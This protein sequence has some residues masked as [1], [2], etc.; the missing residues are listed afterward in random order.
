[1]GGIGKC[2]HE[3]TCDEIICWLRKEYSTRT[4][5][6]VYPNRIEVN[7]PKVRFFGCLGCGSWNADNITSH[8]FG[9]YTPIWFLNS[10]FINLTN[11]LRIDIQI[12]EH[13]VSGQS[14][15]VLETIY[16]VYGM[17][18]EV[19]WQDKDV[20]VMVHYGQGSSIVEVRNEGI[21]NALL[22]SIYL[23]NILVYNIRLV[24]RWMVLWHVLLYIPLSGAGGCWWD[25]NSSRNCTSIILWRTSINTRWLEQMCT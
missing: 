20:N 18:M 7:Y 1:M 8:P 5:F 13:S 4:W 24:V 10:L 15:V 2:F 23:T 22:R 14:D 6:R 19:M 12:E 25:F 17:Y 3:C 11:I 21:Y 16:V 9:K